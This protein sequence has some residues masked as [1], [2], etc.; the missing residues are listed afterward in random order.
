MS[1]L[2]FRRIAAATRD[3]VDGLKDSELWITLGW[4]DIRQ[5][6]RRS[7]AGPFWITISMAMMIGGI[8]Y[9]S[10]G[11]LNQRIDDYLPYLA[12]GIIIFGLVSSL[13]ND[14]SNVFIEMSRAIL[15][16]KAPF[17]L[18]VYQL[19]WR[20]LLIFLHN[21]TIYALVA[22]M[23]RLNPGF[24]VFLGFAGILAILVNGFFLAFILGGLGARFRD[25][26]LISANLMQVA[27]FISPVFWRPTQAQNPL[28]TQLNPFY[29]FLEAARMPL[30]GEVPP[31]QIWWVIALITCV[32]AGVALLF[33]A[34]VRPRIPYWL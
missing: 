22:I 9:L 24:A 5:R 12:S 27:F 30:M 26:P 19:V 3:L 32:N 14:G 34:R 2:S 31:A 6:Y 1:Q 13:V 4:H 10:S 29:Y 17:S 7:V 16:I 20:N 33:F 8:G 18:Y 25:V 11:I 28:F 23:F 15:Q 21:I